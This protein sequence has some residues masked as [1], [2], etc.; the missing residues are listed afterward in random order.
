MPVQVKVSIDTE[1]VLNQI[2]GLSDRI[3]GGLGPDWGGPAISM[4]LARIEREWFESEGEGTWPPLSPATIAARAARYGYYA[5]PPAAGVSAVSPILQWTRRLAESLGDPRGR[6]S[7]DAFIRMSD[8]VLEQGTLVPYALYHQARGRP[9]VKPLNEQDE[10][11]LI[12]V[13]EQY[14]LEGIV[15]EDE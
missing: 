4:E 1:S 14:V 2:E 7:A 9:P 11:R 12:A 8:T 5:Q 15:G 13:F 3:R 10:A 6:G